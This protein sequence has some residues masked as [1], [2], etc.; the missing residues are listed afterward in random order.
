MIILGN[1]FDGINYEIE[2]VK[3]NTITIVTI[4]NI[5]DKLK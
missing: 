2:D 4:E 5:L 1:R 3:N